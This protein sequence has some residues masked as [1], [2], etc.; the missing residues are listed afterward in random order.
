MNKVLCCMAYAMVLFS[1]ACKT[2]KLIQLVETNSKSSLH[3]DS[4]YINSITSDLT[5]FTSTTINFDTLGQPTSAIITK[6]LKESKMELKRGDYKQNASEEV[7]TKT[8]DVKVDR[9]GSKFFSVNY[10]GLIPAL[11]IIALIFFLYKKK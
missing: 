4:N 3:I 8:K 11:L 1:V 5:S 2:K 9:D 7:E 10:W 6:A